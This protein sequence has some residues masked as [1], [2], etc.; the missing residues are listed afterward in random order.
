MMKPPQALSVVLQG[1]S[2]QVVKQQLMNSF[3][4]TSILKLRKLLLK[5][6]CIQLVSITISLVNIYATIQPIVLL[7]VSNSAN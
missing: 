1:H 3:W 6:G 7:I 2:K 4:R 5:G